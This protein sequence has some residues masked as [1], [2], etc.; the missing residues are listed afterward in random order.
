MQNTSEGQV[1]YVLMHS[2][3]SS[4]QPVR[5][6]CYELDQLVHQILLHV[7]TGSLCKI[8]VFALPVDEWVN[9]EQLGEGLYRRCGTA[10][11]LA[12]VSERQHGSDASII[13]NALYAS[14]RAKVLIWNELI[15]NAKRP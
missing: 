8:A 2:S 1:E 10:T 15:S 9:P 11:L 6:V 14:A 5:T 4:G 12:Q 13:L 7:A 3:T